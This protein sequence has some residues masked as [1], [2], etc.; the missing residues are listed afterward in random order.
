MPSVIEKVNGIVTMVRNAGIATVGSSH[1][2]SRVTDSMR[3]PTST[4]A[5]AVA[6][7][8]MTPASG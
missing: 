2:S 6:S 3:K 4:R 1:S 5:G 8:G 7:G